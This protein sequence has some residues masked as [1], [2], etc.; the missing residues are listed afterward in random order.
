MRQTYRLRLEGDSLP[1][2]GTAVEVEMPLPAS[3]ALP[4]AALQ[5]IDGRW[6]VF[7]V[8][9][10]DDCHAGFRHV[11]RGQDVKGAVVILDNLAP[12]EKIVADGAYLLKAY[13][14]KLA[15]PDEGAHV[16]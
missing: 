12:W 4:Q 7:V 5:Q 3:I 16:H 6:G 1:L 9:C 2:P 14:Q 13:Q 11:V 15:S 8:V 10:G